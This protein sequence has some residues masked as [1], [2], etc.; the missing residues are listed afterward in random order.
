MTPAQPLPNDS[1][2]TLTSTTMEFPSLE[3]DAFN[4]EFLPRAHTKR[5]WLTSVL[6]YLVVWGGGFLVGVLV[7]RVLAGAMG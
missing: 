7:D 3:D 2:R 6:I 5:H 1:S 4:E